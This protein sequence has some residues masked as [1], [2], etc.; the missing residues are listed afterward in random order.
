M[1]PVGS[2]GT[3]PGRAPLVGRV[4]ERAALAGASGRAAGGRPVVVSVEGEAGV[5]KSALLRWLA[6]E[7]SPDVRLLAASGEEGEQR[8]DLGVAE[9]LLEEAAALGVT[10]TARFGRAGPRPE[11]FDVGAALVDVI[12]RLAAAEPVLVSVDD[13]QWADPPSVQALTFAVRRLRRLPV[14]VV[15][16][17]RPDAD[18]LEPLLRLASGDDGERLALDGL[19]ASEVRELV[20][21]RQ[22]PDLSPRA[23]ERLRAHA[24]GLPLAVL[25]LADE[26][27]PEELA[28]GIGALPAPRSYATVMLNRLAACSPPVERVVTAVAVVGAPVA[29]EAIA[30]VPGLPAGDALDAVVEES[31]RHHLL[32]TELR[33]GRVVLDVAHP[34]L[35]SAILQDVTPHRRADLHRWAAEVV[36]D[37]ARRMLHRLAA[38]NGDDP[39][40]GREAVALGV[41]RLRHGWELSAVE[42]LTA[43][44]DRFPPGMER[45]GALVGAAGGLVAMG[46]TSTARDL[47]AGVTTGTGGAEAQLVLGHLAI[48][49]GDARAATTSLERA[50]T[51]AEDPSTA[52]RA[53]TLLATVASNAALGEPAI[54][55]ARRAL[56][57][58]GA[59][60]PD[61]GHVLM[62]VA[63][64]WALRGEVGA[65]RREV[66]RWRARLGVVGSAQDTLLPSGV[67]LLW[68][69]RIEE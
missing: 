69:G 15:V 21:A 11:P 61:L 12:A 58:G 3:S 45:D 40:L 14:L 35:R 31:V 39:E 37:P 7:R 20:A 65:G 68:D 63:S 41:E 64:G 29:A 9:Q 60:L 52:A 6:D 47:L 54:T 26:L 17:H 28:T 4:A 67:L 22:G 56:E 59:D 51:S 1:V 32:A 44:A 24:G 42:L 23:A 57:R 27:G 30:S 33:A 55:W 2:P 18:H 34:L 43:A 46:D 8:L 49:D 25:A 19:G 66:D 53:A 10:V 5:G 38:S 36:A 48:L 62:M 16:G 13:A 50:W